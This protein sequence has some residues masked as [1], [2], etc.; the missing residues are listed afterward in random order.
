M[1]T[2]EFSADKAK[3]FSDWYNKVIYAA[4]LVDNRYNV[5]GFVVHKPWSMLAFRQIYRL[6]EAELEADGHLP[7]LFPT[8]IP[9]EN[10]EREKEHVEGFEPQVF[11]VTRAGA[12]DLKRHLALRPTSE[13]AFYQMYSLWVNGKAD[14]PLKMYQSCSVFRNEPETNPFMRGREF[15]WIEAHDCFAAQEEAMQQVKRDMAVCE[16]VLSHELGLS[17]L[18]F[19]RPAWDTFPGAETTFACD[20]RLPDGKAFQIATTHFLGQKFAK[21]FG[22]RYSDD[23]GAEKF[24]FQTCFGIGVWRMMAAVVAVHGDN[25][26]LMMPFSIAPV[27]AMAIP[28]AG[29]GVDS[30]RLLAKCRE[31]KAVLEKAGIRASVDDSD[32]TP[33]YKY[34]YWEM[35]G[36]PIRI[37]VGEKELTAGTVTLARRDSRERVTVGADKVVAAVNELGFALLESMCERAANDLKSHILNVSTKKE[38]A[39]ALDAK[40]YARAFLCSTDKEGKECADF[41]QAETKGGKVRGTLFGGDEAVPRGAKCIHCGRPASAIVYIARQY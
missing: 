13:T 4:D 36:V 21:A 25:K 29:K 16:R 20:A 31:I 22:I 28:I 5:Q 41:I 23:S 30:T 33:G 8:V 40:N 12:E 35:K 2:K 26:G 10:F 19:E 34:N 17:F 6:F 14:L 3:D 15:L 1:A 9:E 27:Q 7:A 24:V 11:W 18:F 38:L 37:E 32:K 39:E